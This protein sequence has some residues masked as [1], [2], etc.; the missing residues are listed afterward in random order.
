MSNSICDANSQ[1]IFTSGTAEVHLGS[2]IFAGYINPYRHVTFQLNYV[3]SK[4]NYD[5][6]ICVRVSHAFVSL[7]ISKTVNY[8]SFKSRSHRRKQI[9]K[10]GRLLHK[11]KSGLICFVQ[12]SYNEE[13]R[14][15]CFDGAQSLVLNLVL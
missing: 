4:T 15:T 14:D 7:N 5:S 8:V 12:K 10:V 1:Y 11:L 3:K 6:H 9:Y 2:K 13:G